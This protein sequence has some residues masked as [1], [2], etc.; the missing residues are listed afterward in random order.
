[1]TSP[2][3]SCLWGGHTET[4][5]QEGQ[6][7]NKHKYRASW[8]MFQVKWEEISRGP[9][10]IAGESEEYLTF[11][12][13]MTIPTRPLGRLIKTHAQAESYLPLHDDNVAQHTLPGTFSY[14]SYGSGG[15]SRGLVEYHLEAMLR[16]SRGGSMVTKMAAHNIVRRHTANEPPLL[17]YVIQQ[18]RTP[19]IVRS[20]R[21]VPGMEDARLS[22]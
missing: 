21:L 6:G 19:F 7:N 18:R 9:L 14:Y 8:H 16:Y 13:E 1:M 12:F 20:Q 15:E 2:P 22:F 10:H 11:P 3:S 5:I 17:E 4:K